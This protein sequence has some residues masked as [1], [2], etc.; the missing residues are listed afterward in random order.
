MLCVSLCR[1]VIQHP[2]PGCHLQLRESYEDYEYF[3]DGDIVIGGVFTVNQ[4]M[5]EIP[6]N[7][8]ARLM[9]CIKPLPQFYKNL[10]TFQFAIEQLNNDSLI[11]PNLTVGY[12]A[13]DSCSDGNKAI[14]SVLQILSGPGRTVPNYS[15]TERSKVIGFIGDHHSITTLPI[16]Q[17]LAVYRYSQISYGATKSVLSDRRL[18]PTFFKTL[19]NDGIIYASV[20]KVLAYFG[21]TWIGIL[22]SND[23]SSVTEAALL[24]D[25]LTKKDICVAFTIKMNFDLNNNKGCITKKSMEIIRNSTANVIVFCGTFSQIFIKCLSE[26]QDSLSDRTIV[27]NPNWASNKYLFDLFANLHH[28]LN[29]VTFQ[30]QAGSPIGFN[31]NGEFVTPYGIVNWITTGTWKATVKLLGVLHPSANEDQKLWLNESAITWKSGGHQIPDSRCSIMCLPGNRKI[32]RPG[33]KPCCCDCVPCSEGEI[34][35]TTDSENCQKC[36]DDEWPNVKRDLCVPRNE[37]FLSYTSDWIS[38]VFISV[39][40]FCFFITHLILGIFISHRH[41]PIVKANNKTLSF[42]LLVSI[43]LSFLCVFLFLGRPVDV[44]C[45][46]RQVSFGILFSVAVSSVLAKTIMVC[47]AF[48]ATKP[49]SVW[50]QW[51]GVT[52]PNCVVFICSSVQVIIS[53]I[54]LSLSAPFQELD[55]HSYQGKIIIQCNEGSVIGFYSILG[56][57]GILAAVSF[58]TAFVART[59][60]DS[61]NE[62]KYITFSMLVFCSVWVAMIPAYLSTKGK[63]MVAVEIFSILT[64]NAGLLVCIFLPKCYIILCRPE[65]NTKMYLL[66]NRNR[67]LPQFYKNLLTF[68]F[69]IEQ[70]NHDSLILPNLTVGYHAYDSCSDGNKAIKSVLQILSGPGRTVPNYSCTER[71]KVIGFIGDHHSIT[72]LPIAQLLVVYQYLQRTRRNLKKQL[73]VTNGNRYLRRLKNKKILEE[74]INEHV[75]HVMLYGQFTLTFKDISLLVDYKDSSLTWAGDLPVLSNSSSGDNKIFI[76]EK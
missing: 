8:I 62:A 4:F 69:A 67:P 75:E 26:M 46:L 54:W 32:P 66:Q 11:L 27:L 42:L 34:S 40:V 15:C 6:R 52:L 23:D 20:S 50:R 18:Y 14:K 39:S 12:H 60:P 72:T 43:M 28:Y 41:T 65:L 71:G 13:Y 21:W 7:K 9:M 73:M 1:P 61:F 59:L 25:Y 30:F 58:V 19:Q 57:M 37:D 16:A 2:V 22:A 48:T 76:Q 56:Y 35:N 64:S 55:T 63:Y 68:Q 38:A 31:E 3:Q 33:S 5:V 36:Q 51:M 47:I 74:A 44:T 53:I 24:T 49:G 17:L 70:L 10:L 45:M 29:K